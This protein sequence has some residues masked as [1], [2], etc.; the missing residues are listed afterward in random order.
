M[1]AMWPRVEAALNLDS[2]SNQLSRRPPA[3]YSPLIPESPMGNVLGFQF[4][5]DDERHGSNQTGELTFFRCAGVGRELLLSLH[6]L[7]A[8]DARPGPHVVLLSGT[9]WAGTSTRYHVHADVDVI[10]KPPTEEIAAIAQSVFRTEFLRDADGA[11][12]KL[13]GQSP[14]VR[15]A[16]LEQML[17]QLARP[18]IPGD[19]S[20]LALELAE[21]PDPERRRA[22]ILVGSYDEARRAADILDAIPEW[23][24]KVCRLV[25]DDADLDDLWQQLPS[26]P[27]K[28]KVVLRRGDVATFKDTGAPLLVAPLLA[29]ERGHNILNNVGQAAIGSAYFLVRP[30]PRPDD[31]TLAVQA[32]NDW[33][34]RTTRDGT[35]THDAVGAGSLDEAGR[36]FRRKA[37]AQW[38]RLI[39]RK[40]AWSSLPAHEKISFTWDQMVV[41]WQVIGR[42]VRGGVPARVHFVDAAF[43]PREAA[44]SGADTDQTSLL[45]S[46]HAVLQPYFA[47][48]SC[49][50]PLDQALV[51]TLYGPLH[52]ALSRLP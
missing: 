49:E 47:E 52:Q 13:S 32:I 8:A 10:L 42:L 39:T 46:M 25:S 5:L 35:F 31:L 2:T 27:S 37:R 20:P 1:T 6:T 33:A 30:H 22:L 7:T 16:V 29:V 11:A 28:G 18:Q 23:S 14:Q 34:V 15:T 17:A 4:R 38:R 12:L 21:I 24:G 26:S 9:S 43:A 36:M 44:L 19:P 41:I 50:A 3:D 45:R 51:R 48:N 40:V